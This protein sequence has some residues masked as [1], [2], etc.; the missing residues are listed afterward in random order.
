MNKIQM[1]RVECNDWMEEREGTLRKLMHNA[2]PEDKI[3]Y[4]AQIDFLSVIKINLSVILKRVEKRSF[5][6]VK[7]T[8]PINTIFLDSKTSIEDSIAVI[9]AFKEKCYM[10]YYEVETKTIRTTAPK[11]E[12]KKLSKLFKCIQS[13]SLT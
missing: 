4:Q 11:T 9:K 7:N 3:K 2:K 8:K 6:E 10:T 1:I 13:Y 12:I 5:Q